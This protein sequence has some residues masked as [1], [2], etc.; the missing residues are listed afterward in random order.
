LLRNRGP[1][2]KDNPLRPRCIAQ[3]YYKKTSEY[4]LTLRCAILHDVDMSEDA[5]AP[6]NDGDKS[7]NSSLT[8]E[9]KSFI[10]N[11]PVTEAGDVLTFD[12]RAEYYRIIASEEDPERRYEFIT[13]T[14]HQCKSDPGIC[15]FLQKPLIDIGDHFVRQGR[16]MEHA[17]GAYSMAASLLPAE[18][19]E[20]KR[21]E[22]KL[23]Y[24]VEKWAVSLDPYLK[25]YIVSILLGSA[26]RREEG[27]SVEELTASWHQKFT[28]M[29]AWSEDMTIEYIG[30]FVQEPYTLPAECTVRMLKVALAHQCKM[31]DGGITDDNHK[32]VMDGFYALC[33]LVPLLFKDRQLEM[34][35]AL[36]V[37]HLMYR[38]QTSGRESDE[39]KNLQT[40]CNGQLSLRVPPES[41]MSQILIAVDNYQSMPYYPAIFADMV[42]DT[43]GQPVGRHVRAAKNFPLTL[44]HL[45]SN[46]AYAFE[47]SSEYQV[48]C[49]IAMSDDLFAR[50]SEHQLTQ[51][52]K[53]A[54]KHRGNPKKHKM[55]VLNIDRQLFALNM[56][57]ESDDQNMQMRDWACERS[58]QLRLAHEATRTQIVLGQ[59]PKKDIK[60]EVAFEWGA[61]HFED[62]PDILV[63]N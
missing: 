16:D 28:E 24:L 50:F 31:I 20:H 2:V 14:V 46:S 61:A 9:Q 6:E 18:A 13:T 63:P 4:G 62:I 45:V 35:Y 25:T 47:A 36:K 59:T 51:Y 29:Q 38:A 34:K 40:L 27:K 7:E 32:D 15:H 54:E 49:A 55:P 44:R 5:D 23:K 42:D 30:D 22:A 33:N 8:G 58:A 11:M 10:E 41:C 19:A 17:M 3:Q 48:N 60:R 53:K 26:K 12:Q 37:Q 57:S 52:N 1:G 21:A 56:F 39:V 43:T